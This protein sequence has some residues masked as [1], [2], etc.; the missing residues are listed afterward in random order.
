M[1]PAALNNSASDTGGGEDAGGGEEAGG[2]ALIGTGDGEA[3]LWCAA[4]RWGGPVA[5]TGVGEAGFSRG[6]VWCGGPIAGAG[7]GEAGLSRGVR[8]GGG[9]GP[10]S[11]S[12]LDRDA[13]FTLLLL[14]DMPLP[15][16]T[17]PCG[18]EGPEA[19]A[20]TS[21]GTGSWSPIVL[22]ESEADSRLSSSG[23]RFRG[24]SYSERELDEREKVVLERVEFGLR[25]LSGSRSLPPL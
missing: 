21:V 17:T 16:G 22:V 24:C 3:G 18:L 12:E 14:L 6:A 5:G 1:L 11:S 2:G 10:A 4:M 13:P 19:A 20:S 15:G 8:C 9:T 23:G 7:V 25:S